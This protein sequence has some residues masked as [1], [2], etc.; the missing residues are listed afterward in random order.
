MNNITNSTNNNNTRS[1]GMWA[2]FIL[3]FAL[4]LLS[5][6]ALAIFQMP[7]ASA[8]NTDAPTSALAM[9][10]YFF[11]GFTPSI[12][13]FIMTY[14]LNGRAG[15][16]DMWKRFTQF[17]L[18]PK[19]YLVIV[20]IPFIIQAG[21]ALIYKL[22]GGDFFRSNL[23]DQPAGLIPLIIAIFIGGP[24]SEEFGWRGFAQ[25]RVQ[26]RWGSLKGSIVLGLA[27]ALW[28]LPLFFAPGTGQQQ[29]GNPALMVPV[30]TIWVVAMA[31][32]YSWVYNN[33]N[34]SL[35]GA[36]FFHFMTNFGANI[37][38]STTEVTDQFMYIANAVMWAL[39]AVIFI[40]FARRKEQP[41][42]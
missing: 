21:V 38:L 27:W 28:H 16:R 25:D 14:R 2:F 36:V 8:A 31:I 26:A 22:Q 6:G 23:L 41:E 15:L 13:G 30:F 29:T 33:T 1:D 37:L 9:A 24:F 34:R 20:A 5:W 7:V 12:A 40:F 10:L 11:G 19:W 17:D 39:L 32:L 35:W 18:R 3:T 4:M 42:K